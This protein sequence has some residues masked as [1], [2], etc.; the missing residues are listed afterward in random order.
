MRKII[1]QYETLKSLLAQLIDVSGYR[2]EYIAR[3]I[4][5][6]QSLFSHKKKNVTWT[7]KEVSAI[8]KV[9]ENVDTDEF[10]LEKITKEDHQPVKKLKS[11]H[12]KVEG[13]NEKTAAQKRPVN[14]V[15]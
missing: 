7:D 5:M 13:K 14:H 10:L 15:K 2:H 1:E 12:K 3:K 6:S 11:L 9:I 4:E 8:I